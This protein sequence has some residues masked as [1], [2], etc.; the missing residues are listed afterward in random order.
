MLRFVL[1]RLA[2]GAGLLLAMSLLAFLG[3]FALGNPIAALVNPSSP[4]EVIERVTRELGLDLPWYAQYLRFMGNLLRGDLGQSY[5]TGQPALGLILERF[6]ATIELTVTAMLAAAVI[7]IPLGVMAGY[8]P[9]SIAGRL[10]SGMS[11]LVLSLPSFWIGLVL[12]IVFAIELRWLPTGGRAA[13]GTVL[14]FE[15]SLASWEGVRRMALPALN[16]ALFPLALLV[17]LTRAGVQESLAAPFVR[18]A[19][20]KGLPTRRILLVYVLRHVLVPVVTVLGIVFGVLLAF[21]VVTESLFSWPGTG[22]LVIDA[23][24]A[25]DRP[26]VIAY[27]L[28]TVIVFVLVNF[29]VDVVCGLIDPRISLGKAE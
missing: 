14:G 3:I 2:Q 5:V 25:S 21:A 1:R 16:L 15:T 23:I 10:A 18:Y 29:V 7:G 27:L 24:R 13:T 28:F 19:R 9:R 12:I 17:R 11:M 22:K 8:R 4:P 6:P 26:V 20:A